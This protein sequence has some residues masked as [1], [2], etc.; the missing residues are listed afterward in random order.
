MRARV[1]VDFNEMPSPD[2]VLLSQSDTKLD[3]MGAEV[4]FVQ[5][6]SVAVYQD[7]PDEHGRPD[8]LVADGIAV[9]NTRNDWTSAAK[10]ILRIDTR[11]I[12]RASEEMPN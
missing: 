12:R 9:L 8:Q 7:D 2:E 1:Y 6:G 10:W 3:S 4:R 11:G 5:G